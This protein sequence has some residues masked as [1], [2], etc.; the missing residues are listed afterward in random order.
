VEIEL[1][2]SVDGRL[3]LLKP[4]IMSFVI[5]YLITESWNVRRG[6]IDLFTV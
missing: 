6:L 2:R 3:K 4:L 1:A 5:T